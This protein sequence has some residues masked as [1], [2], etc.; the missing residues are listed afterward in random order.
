VFRR[1][2]EESDGD[3]EEQGPTVNEAANADVG[4]TAETTVPIVQDEGKIVIHDSD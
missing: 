1:P 4:A 2:G 3:E